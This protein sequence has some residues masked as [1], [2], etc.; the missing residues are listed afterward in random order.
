MIMVSVRKCCYS[1]TFNLFVTP[2]VM[3]LVLTSPFPMPMLKGMACDQ[4]L[5]PVS[6]I[7]FVK[8]VL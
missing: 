6:E 1:P 2:K 5:G 7:F 4:A 8:T 3:P